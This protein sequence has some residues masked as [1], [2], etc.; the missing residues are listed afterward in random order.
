MEA[1]QRAHAVLAH[2]TFEARLA[3]Y[4]R[5]MTERNYFLVG[6]YQIHR[7]GDLF[8]RG[9]L[10]LN[11]N[12]RDTHAKAGAFEVVVK[13]RK[14]GGG[15]RGYLA[16]AFAGAGETI[17]LEVDQDCVVYMLSTHLGLRWPNHPVPERRIDHRRV[18]YEAAI[19]VGARL[20]AVDGS[21]E[22]DEIAQLKRFFALDEAG[23][24]DAGLLFNEG[25]RDRRPVSTVLQTFMDAFPEAPEVRESFLLGMV[26]V[27]L[28]DGE[29]HPAEL[30]LLGEVTT[31]LAL[32]DAAFGRVLAAAG[33][34]IP[35][36][37]EEAWTDGGSDERLPRTARERDLAT[38][39][40]NP[41]ADHRAI[42][43]AW[44]DLV[45]SHHPDIL[46]GRGLPEAEIRH[47]E[48]LLAEINGAYERLQAASR[49][50]LV[51]QLHMNS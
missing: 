30:A 48:A 34:Q 42:V 37:D 25:L 27:M 1:L 6:P 21:A 24:A 38:L 32:D 11:L 43:A 9:K 40:L 44:R 2:M 36:D 13:E 4:E 12:G 7:N 15:L 18:F 17:P 28:A 50:G 16:N 39:G 3:S 31:A 49:G 35:L 45:R 47:A 5:D 19:L 41:G 22:P 26:S 14:R 23:I 8:K 46:R 29:I 51:L 10:V 33:L 20:A